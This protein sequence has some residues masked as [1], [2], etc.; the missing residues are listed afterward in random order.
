[1]SLLI[2]LNGNLSLKSKNLR[3]YKQGP[4]QDDSDGALIKCSHLMF[5]ESA[6]DLHVAQ[7]KGLRSPIHQREGLF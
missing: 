4:P 7:A 2:K 1:M 3:N 6:C 5:Q